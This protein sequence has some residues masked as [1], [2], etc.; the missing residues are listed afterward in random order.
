M[1][2][3]D[4]HT[5]ILSIHDLASARLRN[6]PLEANVEH[7]LREIVRIA[8]ELL[9]VPVADLYGNLTDEDRLRMT[10]GSGAPLGR[11]MAGTTVITGT[12]K[13]PPGKPWP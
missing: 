1:M 11:A 6:P 7:D 8:D 9:A 4:D 2:T 3:Q 12:T 13:L 5:K 10:E